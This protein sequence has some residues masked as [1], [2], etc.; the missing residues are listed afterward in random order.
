MVQQMIIRNSDGKIRLFPKRK[1]NGRPN[2]FRSHGRVF[3]RSKGKIESYTEEE[4]EEKCK[5][6]N[7]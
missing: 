7:K 4:Y 3:V 1:K 6:H 2:I 5:T